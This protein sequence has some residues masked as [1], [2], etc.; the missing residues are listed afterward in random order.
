MMARK[1]LIEHAGGAYQ[2]TVR[3]NPGR[4]IH[5]DYAIIRC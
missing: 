3:G 5:G 4:D 1:L 2:V